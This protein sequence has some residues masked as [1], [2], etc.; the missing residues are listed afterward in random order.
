VV[1]R[2]SRPDAADDGARG[3]RGAAE[4][5]DIELVAAFGDVPDA[6]FDS[7]RVGEAID[8]LISNAIKFSPRGTTVRVGVSRTSRPTD[9]VL[10]SV[11]DEGPGLTDNDRL[12]LFQ[13]FEKLSARPT[14]GEQSTGLG[15][16]IVKKIVDAHGGVV[17][18]ESTPGSGA[19]FAFTVPL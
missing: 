6:R 11:R 8:N 10:V 14:D 18:V 15:L 2:Q 4:A 17:T 19:T 3:L 7:V 5:K 1:G 16:S 9:A 13:K 12:R